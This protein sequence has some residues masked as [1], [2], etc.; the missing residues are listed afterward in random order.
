MS[1]AKRQ[2]T[3]PSKFKRTPNNKFDRNVWLAIANYVGE[4]DLRNLELA[5]KTTHDSVQTFRKFRNMDENLIPQTYARN[6]LKSL[7]I[8]LNNA[9]TCY[10]NM[11]LTVNE[12][13]L[14]FFPDC[15]SR[16][17]KSLVDMYKHPFNPL[18]SR[19]QKRKFIALLMHR[20]S[21]EEKKKKL[22]ASK[23]LVRAT[24]MHMQLRGFNF[25]RK[26]HVDMYNDKLPS[27]I[28]PVN[29][30]IVKHLQNCDL[31]LRLMLNKERVT[32]I[33][34]QCHHFLQNIVD[35]KLN[36]EHVRINERKL[37]EDFYH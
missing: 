14:R 4:N 12:T 33:P 29:S 32:H 6:V 13:K 3:G 25:D 22:D 7:Q 8:D 9:K 1:S 16:T 24:N 23:E 5:S 30:N 18:R 26:T 28:E 20:R 36:Q 2:K 31:H 35:K 27:Q 11:Q 15:F 21:S 34:L 10:S 19:K 17:E 37:I